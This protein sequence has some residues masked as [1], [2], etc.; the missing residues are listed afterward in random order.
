[1]SSTAGVLK[2]NRGKILIAIAALLIALVAVVGSG[3][4]FTSVSS[5]PDNVFTAGVLTHDNSDADSAFMTIDDMVPGETRTGSVTLTNTGS[6]D[7][8]LWLTQTSFVDT[9]GGNGGNLSDVLDIEITQGATVVYSGPLNLMG[10]EAAGTLAVGIATQYDWAVTFPDGGLPGG[11]TT[12]D[13][14]YQG[15]S[16]DVRYDWELVSQ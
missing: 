8:D 3:A 12:G 2:K 11:A 5:N 7:G 4:Y 15:S 14:A 10:T 13:N 6:V 16:V 9:P 1:M